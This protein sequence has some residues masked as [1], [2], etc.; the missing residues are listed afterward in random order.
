MLTMVK[1]TEIPLQAIPQKHKAPSKQVQG[2]LKNETE[3]KI[4]KLLKVGVIEISQHE[5]DEVISHIFIAPK[6]D[7]TYGLI[8]KL[9]EFNQNVKA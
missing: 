7:V 6:P 9:K 1:G 5:N 4:S 3:R 2:N 8:L